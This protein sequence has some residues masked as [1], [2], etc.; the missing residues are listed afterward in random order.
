MRI[1]VLFFILNSFI[2][3]G[4]DFKAIKTTSVA[5]KQNEIDEHFQRLINLKNFTA[6]AIQVQMTSDLQ[7]LL[8][9][10]DK[11]SQ[12]ILIKKLQHLIDNTAK[13]LHSEEE[14]YQLA[15]RS[16]LVSIFYFCN[17]DYSSIKATQYLNL[18]T[19][20]F[21]AL[22]HKN[23]QKYSYSLSVSLLELLFVLQDNSEENI[24]P[25]IIKESLNI[26]QNLNNDEKQMYQELLKS[27]ISTLVSAK[28]SQR[29]QRTQSINENEKIFQYYLDALK[30]YS[31]D[32]NYQSL[33]LLI[34]NRQGEFYKENKQYTKALNIY[35][36]TFKII[37]RYKIYNMQ[38]STIY[39]NVALINIEIKQYDKAIGYYGKVLSIKLQENEQPSIEIA[40]LSKKIAQI[41]ELQNDTTNAIIFYKQSIQDL[42]QLSTDSSYE[43]DLLSMELYNLAIIYE[44]FYKYPESEQYYK[45]S[46]KY[47]SQ[48]YKN[49]QKQYADRFV[50]ILESMISILKKQNKYSEIGNIYLK[51]IEVRE[52]LAK[53]NPRNY[54]LSL[55]SSIED[56]GQL[57]INEK[58]YKL[59]EPHYQRLFKYYRKNS[60]HKLFTT[61]NQLELIYYQQMKRKKLES[62]YLLSIELIKNELN[63]KYDNIRQIRSKVATTYYKLFQLYIQGNEFYKATIAYVNYLL[64]NYLMNFMILLFVWMLIIFSFNILLT[65]KIT[66]KIYRYPFS[67]LLF[68]KVILKFCNA[69]KTQ[70]EILNISNEKYNQAIKFAKSNSEIRTQILANL[71]NTRNYKVEGEFYRI[72]LPEHFPLNISRLFVYFTNDK[73]EEVKEKLQSIT[74]TVLVINDNREDQDKIHAYA[75]D[76]INR[77]IAPQSHEI[78]QILLK[79]NSIDTFATIIAKQLSLTYISPY[80]N[81]GIVHKD[82]MFFGRT[83]IISNIINK[84]PHNYIIVGARQLGKSSLLTALT[85]RYSQRDMEAYYITLDEESDIVF[86][87][88]KA[89]ECANDMR[90][91]QEV[92]YNSPKPIIFLIDEVD[93][94]LEMTQDSQKFTSIFRSLAQGD[95]AYFILAG[96][97]ELYSETLKPKSPLRNFGDIIRL[98]GLEIEACRELITQPMELMGIGYESEEIVQSIIAKSGRRS[99]LVSVICHR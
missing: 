28:C 43:Q 81:S 59:A 51:I 73:V 96:F 44:K 72:N 86:H 71:L 92:I 83:D 30:P 98:D 93:R 16:Y 10:Y 9:I 88:S 84:K 12:K 55:Y 99:N 56:L 29:T 64:S 20:I 13:N 6:Q 80:Q 17:P 62:L 26:Y 31:N 78:T 61:I 1:L 19:S 41:Y 67:R 50:L 14:K 38:V 42:Q 11:K 69:Y 23:Y 32:E 94:F 24:S 45:E 60:S 52:Y 82:S 33:F 57:Y 53:I 65:Y 87:L 37:D 49:N 89:L 63:Q 47:H 25:D 91:I 40:S 74:D 5:L 39:K 66:Y 77:I 97:W 15:I 7:M 46:M 8:S 34:L 35:Q 54:I 48:L 21:K 4:Y 85:R 75:N 36:K 95:R 76:K 18:T 58:K 79:P 27:N 90:S 3:A 70:L 22:T 2:L 68:I